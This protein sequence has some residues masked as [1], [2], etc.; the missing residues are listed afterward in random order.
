MTPTSQFTQAPPI[1]GPRPP[2]LSGGRPFRVAI[3]AVAASLLTVA[4]APSWGHQG[5]GL[6]DL[7]FPGHDHPEP[8]GDLRDAIKDLNETILESVAR[9]Q[10][11]ELWDLSYQDD[12]RAGK[13]ER[14]VLPRPGSHDGS[15]Q[16]QRTDLAASPPAVARAPSSEQQGSD[17]RDDI[18]LDV[19]RVTREPPDL[20]EAILYFLLFAQPKGER[21]GLS[22]SASDA[23]PPEANAGSGQQRRTDPPASP[24]TV[25]RTPSPGEQG[26]DPRDDIDFDLP[27]VSREPRDRDAELWGD[28]FFYGRYVA[29]KDERW[30]LVP[31]ESDAPPPGANAGSGQQRRTTSV[32]NLLDPFRIVGRGGEQSQRT[33]AA[34]ASP[35][36]FAVFRNFN[37]PDRFGGS[38][39]QRSPVNSAN[40]IPKGPNTLGGADRRPRN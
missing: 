35:S 36:G 24:L 25:A 30:G 26:S 29:P 15:S 10:H 20:E 13:D 33:G 2:G 18:E 12:Y 31:G 17:P 4:P 8:H 34:S 19:P 23:T 21:W 28:Y 11:D 9:R 27:R 37:P 1:A 40:T 22:S 7:F 14:W 16:Q 5:S 32:P 3:L 38:A 6:A 39:R